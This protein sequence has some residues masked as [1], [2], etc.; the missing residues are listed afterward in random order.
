MQLIN[1][2]SHFDRYKSP[3]NAKELFDIVAD[4]GKYPEFLP[5][6][7]NARIHDK[8]EGYFLA[9]LIVN[10]KGLSQSYTSK[11]TTHE[12]NDTNS[13]YEINVDLV[14][15]PFKYLKTHW[16]FRPINKKNTEIIFELDFQFRSILLDKMIGKLFESATLKMTKAFEERADDIL[17]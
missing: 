1:M 12:P 6:V 14:E 13:N 16:I 7:S 4:V 9:D 2:P 17:G 5:W 10:F 3:H 15:G 8:K 11:V